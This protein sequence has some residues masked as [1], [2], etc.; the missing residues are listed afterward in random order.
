MLVIALLVG[1][2]A[3]VLVL[4]TQRAQDAFTLTSLKKHNA[5][6]H[7]KLQTLQGQVQQDTTPSTIA[8]RAADL[9]MQPGGDPIF[10]DPTGKILG[11]GASGTVALSSGKRIGDLVVIGTP[12]P[13]PVTTPAPSAT[14]STS[15]A[16]ASPPAAPSAPATPATPTVTPASS[17]RP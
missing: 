1:G 11:L 4:N 14:A 9:G 17:A 2:L 13:K 10:V 7:D 5:Q 15:A 8:S 3:T 12:K 6:L 16:A